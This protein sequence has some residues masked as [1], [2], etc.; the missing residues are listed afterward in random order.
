MRLSFNDGSVDTIQVVVLVTAS[1]TTTKMTAVRPMQAVNACPAGKASFLIPII[2]QPV[3]QAVMQVTEPQTVQVEVIDDCGN[4]V[5]ASN[6][7]S[8]QVTFNSGDAGVDL[9]DMGT[10]IWEATWTPVNAASQVTLQVQ[11]RNRD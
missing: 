8:V 5:T 9:H 1:G 7:G 10:G 11:P 6:G 4:P 2:Q 3:N